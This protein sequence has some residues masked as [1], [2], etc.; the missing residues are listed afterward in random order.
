V[1]LRLVY[2]RQ[3]PKSVQCPP[4]HKKLSFAS[5]STLDI[6]SH[7]RRIDKVLAALLH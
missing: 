3:R 5:P 2:G 7:A 6:R 4:L 1:A